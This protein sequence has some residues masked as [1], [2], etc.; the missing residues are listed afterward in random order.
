MIEKTKVL[1][2]DGRVSI[3]DP[4][5]NEDGSIEY[6][7]T[8][9]T[10]EPDRD[11]DIVNPLGVKGLETLIIAYNHARCHN[12]PV[13]TGSE[14]VKGSIIQN[15]NELRFVVRIKESDEMFLCDIQNKKFS[16]GKLLE[17]VKNGHVYNTSLSFTYNPG[18]LKTKIID[19][20]SYRYFNQ[21][22][23]R[24][25]SLLDVLSSN[26]K[27]IIH[28]FMQNT[29]ETE[30]INKCVQCL[31]DAGVGS[32]AINPSGN[33]VKVT[34][35]T[36]MTVTATDFDGNSIT[37]DDTYELVEYLKEEEKMTEETQEEE[38]KMCSC[39]KN[40]S[41]VEE[42]KAESSI[43]TTLEPVET[44]EVAEDTRIQTIFE[45]LTQL[46]TTIEELKVEIQNKSNITQEEQTKFQNSIIDSI[47]QQS[48]NKFV[49]TVQEQQ[50]IQKYSPF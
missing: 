31:V 27:T 9:T 45:M 40:K 21:V 22:I 23:A 35:I 37:L 18:D 6:D 4:V 43:P 7:V 34:D 41:Q 12:N 5:V 47:N 8:V 44:A 36:D 1:K 50:Q 14:I 10:N 16:N 28:K 30:E 48:L 24:E 26:P 13:S 17:A 46:S 33:V 2:K 25:L 29:T 49:Q 20:K 39:Q 19:G 3:R 15:E 32:Y 42:K 38:T 11:G